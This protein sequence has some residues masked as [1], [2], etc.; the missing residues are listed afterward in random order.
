[1]QE[2]ID[3]GPAAL[4]ALFRDLDQT[5]TGHTARMLAVITGVQPIP[6]EIYGRGREIAAVWLQWAKDN[7]YL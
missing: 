5:R 7:G 6:P 4:P 2:I 3:L 1:L